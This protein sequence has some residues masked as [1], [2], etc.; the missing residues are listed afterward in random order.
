MAA[1]NMK[2]SIVAGL[3]GTVLGFSGCASQGWQ[4]ADVP[5]PR[6]T[7]FDANQMARNAYLEGYRT[8]YR[9]QQGGD[10]GVS[11]MGGPYQEAQLQGFRAG[12][13]QARA[14]MSG[15]VAPVT[16]AATK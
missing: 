14:E 7:P 13:A 5:L 3:L 16:P 1:L 6:Q 12:A 4:S 11:L 15:E 9:A 8:G 10:R 2:I